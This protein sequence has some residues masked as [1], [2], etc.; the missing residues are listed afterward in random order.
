MWSNYLSARSIE[1]MGNKTRRILIYG[2]V[3]QK[4]FGGVGTFVTEMNRH[5]SGSTLFDYV[6]E[7]TVCCTMQNRIE[8]LGGRIYFITNRIKNP[9]RNL[10]ENKKILKELRD[11][12][13]AVYFNLS[14]LGW[15]EPIKIAISLGYKVFV[16]SHNSKLSV[17]DIRHRLIHKINRHRLSS[18][19]V[20]RLSCS[21]KATEFMFCP[22]DRVQ[23]IHNAVDIDLFKFNPEER[24]QVRKEIKLSSDAKVIGFVGR[25]VEQKNVLFL[26]DILRNVIAQS[27]ENIVMI[28]IGEG[29]LK[30]KLQERIVQFN[31]QDHCLLLGDHAD[32]NRYYQA[33]DVFLLPSLFEGL[34]IVMTEAQVSGLHCIVSDTITPESDISENVTFLPL[35]IG[36]E[37]WSKIVCEELSKGDNKRKTYGEKIRNTAFDIDSEAKRLELILSC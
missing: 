8:A 10:E 9:L 25:L 36:A 11:T 13:D 20:S 15:I 24:M 33:M 37:R 19:N 1:R 27:E 29:K 26:I 18:F 30:D 21:K 34:P 6:M 31:L 7:G 3:N 23:F 2:V 22:K 12:H 32:V 5:M 28:I 17:D 35:N 14:S 16:H 4:T